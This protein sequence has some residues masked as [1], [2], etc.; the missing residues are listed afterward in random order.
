MQS[1][2]TLAQDIE[3]AGFSLAP[4]WLEQFEARLQLLPRRSVGAIDNE[5][6]LTLFAEASEGVFTLDDARRISDASLVAEYP[7]IGLVF[8]HLDAVGI[9]T[10]VLPNVNDAEW[11]RLFPESVQPEFPALL[12]ARLR[13][14]SH[15]MRVT[16]PDPRSFREVERETGYSGDGTSSSTTKRRTSPQPA[17]SDGQQN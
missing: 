13:F 7:D 15:L 10:A 4:S 9:E 5:R 1:G 8:D 17:N 16:K 3:R 6:F 11:A 12:R 2:R 14:A